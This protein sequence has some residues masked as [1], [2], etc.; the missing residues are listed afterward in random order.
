MFSF[1]MVRDV[2]EKRHTYSKLLIFS[3]NSRFFQKN[4]RGLI[5]GDGELKNGSH[6][7]PY[8][9]MLMSEFE[10]N[11]LSNFLHNLYNEKQIH[12]GTNYIKKLIRINFFYVNCAKNTLVS[13]CNS[14]VKSFKNTL[15]QKPHILSI[16]S[17]T[18][19]LSID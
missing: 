16:K 6:K 18:Y 3:R 9:T 1:T 7:T 13:N 11:I 5:I 4:G 2:K 8:G 15:P 14:Y 17:L 12:F 19:N 10:S